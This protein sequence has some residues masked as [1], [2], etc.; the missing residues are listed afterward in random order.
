M[1]LLLTPTREINLSCIVYLNP[2]SLYNLEILTS[3]N[4][5]THAN[6]KFDT[7][8]P[9]NSKITTS[10]AQVRVLLS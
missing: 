4:Q 6:L 5:A 7:V 3:R 9:S 2:W 8:T 1:I 10:P